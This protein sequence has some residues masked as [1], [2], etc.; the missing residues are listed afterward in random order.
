MAKKSHSRKL[1]WFLL[2]V[3]ILIGISYKSG[4]LDNL[5][6]KFKITPPKQVTKAE[7]IKMIV[8]DTGVAIETVAVTC[9]FTDVD[10]TTWYY[11]YILTACENG[12]MSD[13]TVHPDD[14]IN[15][16]EISKI[17]YWAYSVPNYMPS[18]PSFTD[19]SG[20]WYE[21]FIESLNAAGAYATTSG[22]FKP[23]SSATKVFV[24]Y[25]VD[26]L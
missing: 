20:A 8:I 16:A 13:G 17:A 9:S 6:G 14:Y 25:I 5:Q 15:R 1:L 22:T 24:Q 23:S 3:I 7:A 21:E 4:A 12:W 18:S 2:F 19:I 26:H 11:D 10:P